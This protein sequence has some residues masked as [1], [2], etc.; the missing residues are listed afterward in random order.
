MC[1]KF[2]A[3]ADEG[4]SIRGQREK[5][6]KAYAVG[7]DSTSHIFPLL[8]LKK[9]VQKEPG[10]I[11]EIPASV[12]QRIGARDCILWRMLNPVNSVSS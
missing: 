4:A 2:S 8:I 1:F 3:S 7:M 11:M 9:D 10:H 5:A 6:C 12:I